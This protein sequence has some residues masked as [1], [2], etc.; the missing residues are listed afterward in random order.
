MSFTA[1]LISPSLL[2]SS[3]EPSRLRADRGWLEKTGQSGVTSPPLCCCRGLLREL[4]TDE[5]LSC[6][7]RNTAAYDIGRAATALANSGGRKKKRSDR[8]WTVQSYISWY[9]SV[10]LRRKE[11]DI[12]GSLR[13]SSNARLLVVQCN[14]FDSQPFF[15]MKPSNYC[16]IKYILKCR[17][18]KKTE[19]LI[20][21]T[22]LQIEL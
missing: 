21:C 17:N 8:T 13:M 5:G 18:W 10:G 19:S 9:V 16:A 11:M 4:S 22:P 3:W 6:L 2:R 20:K 1:T 7:I 14:H 15:A 12:L